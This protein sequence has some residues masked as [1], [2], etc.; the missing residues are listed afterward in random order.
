MRK[1]SSSDRKRRPF[2]WPGPSNAPD[3]GGRTVFE[4]EYE[5]E[6]EYE[7][8]YE[9]EHEHEH[10]HEKEPAPRSPLP[11]PHS[12]LPCD[13]AVPGWTLTVEDIFRRD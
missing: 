11:T 4:Y 3:P 2:R 10:E 1:R 12:P 8:E 9:H 7:H 5:Y 13:D 6:Y